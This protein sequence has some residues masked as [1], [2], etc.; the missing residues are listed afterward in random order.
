MVLL[1]KSQQST[2]LWTKSYCHLFWNKVLLAL[3]HVCL[4]V[5]CSWLHLWHQGATALHGWDRDCITYKIENIYSLDLFRG[6]KKKPKLSLPGLE[7]WSPED[8]T[9]GKMKDF[10]M[11]RGN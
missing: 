6:G 5:S 1:S 3:S 2:S 8:G 7:F 4:L 11:S 10:R 9:L